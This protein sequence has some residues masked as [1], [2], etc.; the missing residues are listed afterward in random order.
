MRLEREREADFCP[1]VIANRYQQ[2]DAHT[3]PIKKLSVPSLC[4]STRTKPG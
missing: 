2:P 3:A 4:L 1:D